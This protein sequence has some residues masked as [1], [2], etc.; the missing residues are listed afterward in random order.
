MHSISRRFFTTDNRQIILKGSKIV[1]L[2]F[3]QCTQNEINLILILI[4]FKIINRYNILRAA[5]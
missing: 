5:V 3:C 1:L 2:K 4:A